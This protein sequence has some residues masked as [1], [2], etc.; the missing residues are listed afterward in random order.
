MRTAARSTRNG[1]LAPADFCLPRENVR[2]ERLD[3]LLFK[4]SQ[5]KKTNKQKN[6][7]PVKSPDFQRL[8][9]NSENSRPQ[10]GPGPHATGLEPLVLAAAEE[11]MFDGRLMD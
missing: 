8:C 3:L 4:R 1:Y 10:T 5:N 2:P 9:V 6:P 7:H 11:P